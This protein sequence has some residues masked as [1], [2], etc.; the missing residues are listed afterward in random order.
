MNEKRNFYLL[1]FQHSLFKILLF[2]HNRLSVFLYMFCFYF[3]FFST[4]QQQNKIVFYKTYLIVF[5]H[6]NLKPDFSVKTIIKWF[7]LHTATFLKSSFK[8][9]IFDVKGTANITKKYVCPSLIPSHLF[10]YILLVSG[11]GFLFY[12][13]RSWWYFGKTIK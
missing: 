2:S 9:I 5:S 12:F 1:L 13:G 10:I 6:Q 7:C 4:F 3:V 8:F 11:L